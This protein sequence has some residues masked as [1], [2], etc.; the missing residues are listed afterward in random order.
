MNNKTMRNDMKLKY[1][2]LGLI[3]IVG[4]LASNAQTRVVPAPAQSSPIAL[5]GGTAHLGNGQIIENAIIGFSKGK[6]SIVADATSA[7]ADLEGYEVIDVSGKHIYPGFILMNTRLGLSEVSSVDMTRDFQERGSV[8]PN[9]RTLIAYNTDSEII[10]TIRFNGI[11]MA[12]PAPFSGLVSGTSS[13]VQLD[14]WNWED[15]A[16]KTDDALFIN[17]PNKKNAPRWWMGETEWKKNEKYSAQVIELRS[18]FYEASNYNKL[19][20][21]QDSNLKLEAVTG[22]FG[23]SKGLHIR[24]DDSKSIIE[25]VKFAKELGVKRI[26]VVGGREALDVAQFLSENNIPVV[27][28]QTHAQPQ[29]TEGDYDEPYKLPHL[30]TEAGVLVAISYDGGPEGSRNLPFFAGTAAAY[31]M[32]KEEALKTITMNPAKNLGIENTAGTIEEGKD[33]TLFVSDGDALDMRTSILKSAYI[34][35]RKIQLDARQQWL[36]EKYSKKYEKQD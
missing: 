18:L 12:Q 13:V 21:R 2:V 27:L 34:Q 3:M 8:N 7:S 31:G 32:T 24:V 17:W 25:S 23:G 5:R 16:Y 11:M 35:G 6:L 10:P 29:R 9:V 36:F 28:R 19:G 22:V 15:A 20:N 4:G 1:I 30:L 33:A 14:A 26:V